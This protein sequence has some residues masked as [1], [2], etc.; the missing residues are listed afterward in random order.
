MAVTSPLHHRCTRTDTCVRWG[1]SVKHV[2]VKFL[3]FAV[4]LL[5]PPFGHLDPE[6][7]YKIR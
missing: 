2:A 6:A 3:V 5:K 1:M 4:S 7:V